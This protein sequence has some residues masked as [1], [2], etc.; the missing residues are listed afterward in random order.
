MVKKYLFLTTILLISSAI[1]SVSF[2]KTKL[3][4]SAVNYRYEPYLWKDHRGKITGSDAEV[5][6]EIS[7]RLGVEIEIRLVPWKRVLF[8]VETGFVLGGFPAFKTPEREKYAIYVSTP[9][10]RSIY[11]VFVKKNK[12]FKF[13]NIK[14]LY[15]KIIAI[16]RGNFVS[17]DFVRNCK[18]IN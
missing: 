12:T 6:K 10:R 14:D 1:T 9:L 5:I 18:I 8:E 17:E 7:N 3:I 15:G 16:T 2:G 4:F 11:R 13:N